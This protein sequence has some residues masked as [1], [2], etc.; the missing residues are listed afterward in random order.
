MCTKNKYIKYDLHEKKK[1]I[2]NNLIELNRF[3]PIDNDN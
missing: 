2:K 3:S 1:K